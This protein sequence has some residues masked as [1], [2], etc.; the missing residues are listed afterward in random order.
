MGSDASEVLGLP[1]MPELLELAGFRIRNATRADCARCEGHSRRTVSFT[2]QVAHCFR[3]GWSA[4]QVILARELGVLSNDP[5]TRKALHREWKRRERIEVPI[6]AFEKWRDEELR[7]AT[8]QH[9]TL[10]RQAVLA[11]SV[12]K[13]YP[14]CEPAWTALA[15]FYRRKAQL[16]AQLDRLSCTKL[17]DFLNAP[18]TICQLYSEWRATAYA[19]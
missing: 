16:D 17:S 8:D 5:Q 12:L 6:Q 2:A 3:C 9:R 1:S 11:E 14:D 10:S 4:N 15:T 18:Y 7:R 13:I 19:A